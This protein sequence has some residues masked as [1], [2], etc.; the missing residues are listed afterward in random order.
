MDQYVLNYLKDYLTPDSTSFIQEHV[1]QSDSAV[2]KIIRSITFSVQKLFSILY[3]FVGPAL[4]R[5]T[6]ALYN[7]PDIVVLGFVAVILLFMFQVLSWM[8]RF[9]VFWTRLA[10]RFTFYA[11]IV[12]LA[13]SVYQRGLERSFNDAASLGSTVLGWAGMIKDIWMSEYRRYEQQ[14]QGSKGYS[15]QGAGAGSWRNR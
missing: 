11:G 14:A 4:D 8:R 13:A 3:P 1:F 7:S 12:A 5:L 9:M 10:A 6:Q 15:G 2:G